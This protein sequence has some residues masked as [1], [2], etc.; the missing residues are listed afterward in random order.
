MGATED[1]GR[2]AAD[3]AVRGRRFG[4][5]ITLRPEHREEYL[6]LHAAVWPDVLATLTACHIRNYSIFLE[7]DTLFSY[8]EY[9][10]EDYPA[11]MARMAADPATREWWRL[12]DPCQEQTAGAVPGEWWTPL[13]EVFHHD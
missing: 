6:R 12:T 9:A 5:V 7:G 1:E 10:G 8:F 2:G 3:G 11:D 13:R 4:K